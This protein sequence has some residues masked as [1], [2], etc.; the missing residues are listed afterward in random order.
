[1]SCANTS[2]SSSSATRPMN[3]A[4]PPNDA[5]P[6]HRVRG[7]AARDLGRRAHAVRRARRRAS[8]SIS[9]IAPLHEPVRRR[10]TS[11]V[12]WLEHV[13]ERVADADDV[14]A[15]RA[16]RSSTR[17][18]SQR[19]RGASP[20]VDRA[21]WSS[22]GAQAPADGLGAAVER[23]ALLE[24]AARAARRSRGSSASSSSWPWLAPAAREMFSSISVPPRSLAAGLQRSGARRRRRTSPTTPAR[25]RSSRGTRCGRPRA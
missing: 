7:R 11:S 2:P 18:A 14:E 16:S 13:D 25:C 3:A 15:R 8:A 24:R 21:T 6:D 1:M 17:P 19:R 22:G 10:R 12:S 20:R 4:R 23:R 9:V 5:M